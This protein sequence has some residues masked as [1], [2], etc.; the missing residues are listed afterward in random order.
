MKEQEN[1]AQVEIVQPDPIPLDETPSVQVQPAQVTLE[2]SKPV[3]AKTQKS[4]KNAPTV[5]VEQPQPLA[6]LPPVLNVPALSVQTQPV[7]TE[8]PGKISLVD[9]HKDLYDFTVKTRS[10]LAAIGAR[11]MVWGAAHDAKSPAQILVKM[12]LE[13]IQL[14]KSRV[15]SALVKRCMRLHRERK[16]AN[17]HNVFD[18][19]QKAATDK[20]ATAIVDLKRAEGR[21][22][23]GKGGAD[24]A[25]TEGAS[26]KTP[27]SKVDKVVAAYK[28]LSEAEK[29]QFHQ[30]TGQQ[31]KTVA[32]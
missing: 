28:K 1:P 19:W 21:D 9:I 31:I 30:K 27:L 15:D 14:Q 6:V 18:G 23:S 26:K 13:L 7:K 10:Q 24:S 16:D 29:A 11:I 17:K 12:E 20:D 3:K 8:Q 25:G 4:R 32:A 5:Q 2:A 22:L